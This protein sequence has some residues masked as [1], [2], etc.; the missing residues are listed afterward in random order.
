M[1]TEKITIGYKGMNDANPLITQRFGADPYAMVY[2]D[3]VY[4]YMTADAFEYNTDGSVKENTYSKIH[5]IN[6]MVLSMRLHTQELQNGQKIHGRLPQRGKKLMEK[7]NSFYT[8]QM[9]VV[10]LA[11]CRQ[12]VL[13]D[14]FAI[15]W[16]RD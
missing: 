7:I 15:R 16:E 4:I 5:R 1:N 3:R 11:F 2:K 9:E 10:A 13:R 6:I 8:L 12:T 14:H